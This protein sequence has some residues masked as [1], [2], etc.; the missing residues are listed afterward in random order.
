[1]C[2]EVCI[3]RDSHAH[4]VSRYSILKYCLTIM[5]MRRFPDDASTHTS[6]D[7]DKKETM[8]NEYAHCGAVMRDVSV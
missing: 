1:M 5:N 8:I 6:Q 2:L 3:D 4:Y 7:T